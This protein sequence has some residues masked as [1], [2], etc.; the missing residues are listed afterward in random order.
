MEIIKRVRRY[1]KSLGTNTEG[2]QSFKDKLNDLKRTS[3]GIKLRKR[4]RETIQKEMSVIILLHYINE[5]KNIFIFLIIS[6]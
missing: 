1:S 4:S 6:F 5:I 3:S 2:F